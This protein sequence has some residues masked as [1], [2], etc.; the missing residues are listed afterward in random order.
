MIDGVN[1]V[2]NV[3]AESTWNSTVSSVEGSINTD[4]LVEP[5]RAEKGERVLREL[6]ITED[7]ISAINAVSLDISGTKIPSL[8]NFGEI[9][10]ADNI[11]LARNGMLDILFGNDASCA[12]FITTKTDLGILSTPFK[13]A[14]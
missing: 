10:T 12:S 11:R 9:D 7:V 2:S 1:L 13:A 5:T 4:N 8:I 3:L 14:K 6:G